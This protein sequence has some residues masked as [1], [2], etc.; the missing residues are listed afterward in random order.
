MGFTDILSLKLEDEQNRKYLESIR[1]SGNSLLKLINDIL[2]LSKVE[3]GKLNLNL[4]EIDTRMFFNEI[5]DLFEPKI[6]AKGLELKIYLDKSLP[7][8]IIVDA[9][10]LRQIII[11]LI[12]NAIKFTDKG[13][14]GFTA[15]AE[16]KG[17][18]QVNLIV[19]IEDTGAGISSEFRNK[20]FSYFQQEDGRDTRRFEGTGLG[21]PISRGLAKLMNGVI[22]VDSEREKG[23]IFS[24]V[25]KGLEVCDIGLQNQIE[26]KISINSIKFEPCTVLLVEDNV[27]DREYFTNLLHE[28]GLSVIVS[29]NGKEALEILQKE[30]PE[31]ILSDIRMPLMDGYGLIK[32]VK[33][34][35]EFKDIPVVAITASAMKE[36]TERIEKAGFNSKLIKPVTL[37]DFFKTLMDYLPYSQ[38]EDRDKKISDLSNN[39][40]ISE[41]ARLRLPEVIESLEGIYYKEWLKLRKKQPLEMVR[42]FGEGL[43]SLGTETEI[44]LLAEYGY[45]LLKNIDSFDIK[46]LKDNINKYPDLV[47]TLK[48]IR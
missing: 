29:K 33:D 34:L 3:A 41:A 39:K 24:L 1:S 10:R 19:E 31:L 45:T 32:G 25:L 21:L 9:L 18:K 23:S 47:N 43:K 38:M 17:E 13:Y 20:I 15:R 37:N 2:D 22:S 6:S 46:E 48:K 4:S 8:G 27:E 5:L 7:D 16:K 30:S 42:E 40:D 36:E 28:A 12:S 14:I 35:K 44:S 11:N 26:K